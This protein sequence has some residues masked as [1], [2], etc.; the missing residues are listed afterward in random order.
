MK[1][2]LGILIIVL[3]VVILIGIIIFSIC[4]KTELIK[5]ANNIFNSSNSTI[6]SNEKSEKEK[7]MERKREEILKTN[8]ESKEIYEAELVKMSEEEKEFK[9]REIER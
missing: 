3:I 8:Q 7:E 1:N 9:R 5:I 4:F 6:I 2:K